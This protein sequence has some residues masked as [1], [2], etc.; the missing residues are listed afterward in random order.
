M[1]RAAWAGISA[2]IA[3]AAFGAGAFALLREPSG[4]TDTDRAAP[5][6]APPSSSAPSSTVPAIEQAPTLLVWTSGGMPAAL[7]DEIGA[8][9]GVLRTTTVLGDL[10]DLVATTDANGGP[11]DAAPAGMRIPLDGFAVDPASYAPFAGTADRDAIAR[12]QPG[13]ALLGATSA[14]LRRL[15]PGGALELAN[16]SRVTVTGVVADESVGAAEVVVAASGAPAVGIDTPRFLLVAYSGERAA[17][18][19][20]VAGL[21]PGRP[22]RFRAAGETRFLRHA[23]LVLPQSL[24]K[25]RFGEFA[26]RPGA[27]RFV[28]VD[29][30]YE[31]ANIVTAPVPI[32]GPITCHRAVLPALEGALRELEQ[33][34]LASLIDPAGYQGCF[35]ASIIPG[36]G[37]V[38]RHSWG[39]AVDVNVLPNPGGLPSFADPQLEEV[40]ERWGFVPGSRFINS[41]PGHF[42]YVRPPT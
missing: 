28:M 39:I 20:A 14:G 8:L 27:D 21:V 5:S 34:G 15:G 6:T 35:V 18:E 3:L 37:G 17:L 1:R 25:E 33:R 13:E 31:A 30:G 36:S 9:P 10:V 12:L 24:V 7:T 41:D 29:P 19:A 42:E 40:M 11:V 23:D 16:G 4:S 26:Y 22:V 38:S 32:L 2:V